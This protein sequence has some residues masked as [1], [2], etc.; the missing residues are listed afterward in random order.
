[1]NKSLAYVVFA[2]IANGPAIRILLLTFRNDTQFS[3]VFFLMSFDQIVRRYLTFQY[4]FFVFLSMDVDDYVECKEGCLSVYASASMIFYEA[5][6]W[7]LESLDC[8]NW[9]G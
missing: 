8:M 5:C 6:V 2:M 4:I 1:M 3:A 7:T 9:V